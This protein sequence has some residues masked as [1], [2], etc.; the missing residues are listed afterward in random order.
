MLTERT[1]YGSVENVEADIPSGSA[2]GI[3]VTNVMLETWCIH[4][5]Q[6][7]L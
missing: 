6:R 5:L 1:P 2:I 7:V 4:E 3:D